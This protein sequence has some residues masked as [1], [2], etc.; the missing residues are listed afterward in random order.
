MY[1]LK[2]RRFH[3]ALSAVATGSAIF[4][5]ALAL[6]GKSLANLS[7]RGMTDCVFAV[8]LLAAASFVAFSFLP[9]FRGD[10]R[11]YGISALLTVVFFAGVGLLWQTPLAGAL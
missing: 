2:T 5:L 4:L 3:I 8:M 9:Y 10:K 11:W 6:F 7:Y 1:R